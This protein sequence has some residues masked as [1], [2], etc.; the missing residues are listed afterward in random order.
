MVIKKQT[1]LENEQCSFSSKDFGKQLLIL[2]FFTCTS[3]FIYCYIF[4]LPLYYRI[5][6]K[7]I[8]LVNKQYVVSLVKTSVNSCSFF[9]DLFTSTSRFTYCYIFILPL[10]YRIIKKQTELVN[11]QYCFST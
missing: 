6:K 9:N 5:I 2:T 1:K 7:Q 4:I 10:Y 11:K 8:E 3:R